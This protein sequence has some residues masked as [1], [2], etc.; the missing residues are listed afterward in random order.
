MN[1]IQQ[2]VTIPENRQLL[3]NLT[4]PEDIPAGQAEVLVIFA[5]AAEVFPQKQRG[6][7]GSKRLGCMRGLGVLD[8]NIDIKAIGSEEIISMFEGG[9]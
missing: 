7:S 1:T 5:P 4:I 8:K 6:S 3:L 9:G 2:T